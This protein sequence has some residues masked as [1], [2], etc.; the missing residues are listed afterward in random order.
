MKIISDERMFC[1]TAKWR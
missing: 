1:E